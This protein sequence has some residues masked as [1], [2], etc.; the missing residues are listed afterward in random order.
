[1]LKTQRCKQKDVI[2]DFLHTELL[3]NIC[4]IDIPLLVASAK[5]R[6]SCEVEFRLKRHCTIQAIAALLDALSLT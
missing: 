4:A 3:H 5:A 6:K 1:V 2:S